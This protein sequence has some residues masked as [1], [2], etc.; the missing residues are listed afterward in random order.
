MLKGLCTGAHINLIDKNCTADG[1]SVGLM[2]VVE[3][4][5]FYCKVLETA[6][7]HHRYGLH[8]T[9]MLRVKDEK[10]ATM[11]TPEGLG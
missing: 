10:S 2:A 4:V 9:G 3:Q 1:L 8:V 11:D 6:D 5:V 7:S